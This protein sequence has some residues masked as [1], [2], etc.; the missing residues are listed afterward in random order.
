MPYLTRTQLRAV[1]S[2]LEAQRKES[3]YRRHK[4]SPDAASVFLS[5]SHQD[6]ETVQAAITLLASQG[7]Y[8]YVDWMD[9]TMPAVTSPETALALKKRIVQCDK[10]VLLASEKALES[11]WVPWELGFAD[12]TGGLSQI[13]LIP[14]KDSGTDWSRS[15][16]LGLYPWIEP[17]T[18]LYSST[19]TDYV[20][21]YPDGRPL[22]TLA[23]WLKQPSDKKML[24]L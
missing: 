10:F 5:H 11:R 12:G 8:V 15:E 16:Y 3:L 7:V 2:S 14:F 13:A 20:V 19:V 17:L 1:G 4:I 21:R 22:V 23:S 6:R 9:Q 18:G 24:R